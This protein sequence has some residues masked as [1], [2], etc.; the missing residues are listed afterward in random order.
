MNYMDRCENQIALFNSLSAL[1]NTVWKGK[2]P[3]ILCQNALS[4][5]QSCHYARMSEL[6]PF[7]QNPLPNDWTLPTFC[8][9]VIGDTD[10]LP[11]VL[12]ALRKESLSGRIS[13]FSNASTGE[14]VR[15]SYHLV[16]QVNEIANTALL[17]LSFSPPDRQ[18]LRRFFDVLAPTPEFWLAASVSHSLP[19]S[20]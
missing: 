7:R 14:E 15:H 13:F 6:L 10:N 1:A 16:D 2:T 18:K 5:V 11:I 4:S 3:K 9:E 12:D 8:R 20:N 19:D 17:G